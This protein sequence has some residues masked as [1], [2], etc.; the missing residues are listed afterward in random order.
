M[1]IRAGIDE[2]EP[3]GGYETFKPNGRLYLDDVWV[4]RWIARVIVW[5]HRL[6]AGTQN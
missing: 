5:L 3:V 2:V 6:R 1:I 4:P